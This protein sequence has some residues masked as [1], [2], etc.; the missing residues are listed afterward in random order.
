[1]FVTKCICCDWWSVRPL[2]FVVIGFLLYLVFGIFQGRIPMLSNNN[3]GYSEWVRNTCM[4]ACKGAIW[5]SVCVP[6]YTIRVPCQLSY[7]SRRIKGAIEMIIN[8]KR[9]INCRFQ[10]RCLTVRED[11]GSLK[12]ELSVIKSISPPLYFSTVFQ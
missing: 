1:M 5:G 7:F 4:C 2:V 3:I 6:L 10:Q 12:I 11:E 9:Y 8:K